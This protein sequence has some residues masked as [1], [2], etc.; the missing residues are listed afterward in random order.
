MTASQP[1]DGDYTRIVLRL[2]KD[3]PDQP[4][5]WLILPTSRKE[6]HK[7]R[8]EI[9]SGDNPATRARWRWR[10]GRRK[11]NDEQYTADSEVGAAEHES[12]TR[13]ERIFEA[14]EG[15]VLRE[16]LPFLLCGLIAITVG[17][18][19]EVIDDDLFRRLLSDG[20]MSSVL[21]ILTAGAEMSLLHGSS[22][23][24][25]MRFQLQSIGVNGAVI[26]GMASAILLVA[27][28][29]ERGACA[30]ASDRA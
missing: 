27:V 16:I 30:V 1:L 13:P 18:L 21:H 10:D 7:S 4:S 25:E 14:F 6:S 28:A 12:G 29:G 24:A 11:A 20:L 9:G 22:D 2:V 23:T 19:C 8:A 3:E 15:L 17:H 26:L 5:R